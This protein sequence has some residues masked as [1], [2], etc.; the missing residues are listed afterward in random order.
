M[1]TCWIVFVELLKTAA[2]DGTAGD[3]RPYAAGVSISDPFDRIIRWP[4]PDAVTD[5]IDLQ[6]HAAGHVQS[7][8][9]RL[10][11]RPTS[12]KDKEQTTR[13]RVLRF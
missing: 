12:G 1:A 10:P 11:W 2:T 13:L 8:T 6:P 3:S 7:L 5:E 4:S 9:Q